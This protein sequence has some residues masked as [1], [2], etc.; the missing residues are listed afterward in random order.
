[1]TEKDDAPRVVFDCGVF[2]QG[3]ISESG[4]AVACIEKFERGELTVF[5]SEEIIAEVRDI[6]TRSKLRAKH[7]LLT[8]ERTNRLIENL[9]A[10]AKFFG[11]VPK[12]FTY[13]RDPNDEPYINL[14]VEANA[15]F[16]I[17]RD[18]DLLDLMTGR[19]AE[20]KEFRQRFRPLK[21]VDPVSFLKALTK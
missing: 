3:L 20:C 14:A 5:I 7:P 10:K 4:P 1:V 18:K 21:V 17:S 15:D 16:I 13:E 11:V 8:E 12:H 9:W 2:L 6:L 19:T